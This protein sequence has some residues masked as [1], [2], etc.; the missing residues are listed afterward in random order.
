MEIA[1]RITV[2]PREICWTVILR[3]QILKKLAAMMVGREVNLT[4]EK[5]TRSQ[6]RWLWKSRTSMCVTNAR[7]YCKWIK[8]GCP[9]WEIL[10]VAGV[11]GNGQT[12][13]VYALT[14][15]PNLKQAR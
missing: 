1:D 2:L 8:S 3:K 10:G 7:I 11:Q 14:G 4:V 9:S 13:L 5:T 12:E 15:F 6:K